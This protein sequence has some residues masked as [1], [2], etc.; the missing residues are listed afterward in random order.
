MPHSPVMRCSPVREIRGDNHRRGRSLEGGILLREKN[1]D[2]ALFNEM[3]TR[4]RDSFLLPS[5]DDF[6]DTF[7][8]AVL[9]LEEC[10]NIEELQDKKCNRVSY[11][12]YR[13]G[14]R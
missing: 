9:F 7:R 3:E 1:D 14:F 8:K 2:L 11:S 4:E 13:R 10:Q 5:N 6:E 12:N